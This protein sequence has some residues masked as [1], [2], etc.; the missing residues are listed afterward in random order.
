MR[1]P[2]GTAHGFLVL[3]DTSVEPLAHGELLQWPERRGAIA[4]R[5]II[6]FND[7]STY[8]EVVRFAQRPVLRLL[9]Y[10]LVQRGPS[11]S[12]TSDIAFDRSGKYHARVRESPDKDEEEASGSIVIPEDVSNGMTSLV[13]KNLPPGASGMTHLL[14]FTP[15]PQVLELHL[16]PQ[17]ADQFF[18][19]A[20]AETAM[21]FLMEP[22]VPGV[23]GVLATV[24]GKQPPSFEMWMTAEPAPSLVKFE[25]P[26]YADGPT[27]RIGPNAPT[28]RR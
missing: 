7:G 14:A 25:G 10:K 23:K 12:E 8:D 20:T 2:E 13:L 26:L 19:G 24:T 1:Y 21:R 18:V 15:K 6:R 27:W 4:S 28:W 5:L 17:G 3:T 22:K 9:S 11:F 16:T